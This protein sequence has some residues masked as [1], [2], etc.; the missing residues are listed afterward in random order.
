MPAHLPLTA[1]T[2]LLFATLAA[3]TLLA[4]LVL[5]L[6]SARGGRR[7]QWLVDNE[8]SVLVAIWAVLALGASFGAYFFGPGL[9]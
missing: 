9:W 2:L 5:R 6:L 4:G 3:V 1:G 8:T 7:G